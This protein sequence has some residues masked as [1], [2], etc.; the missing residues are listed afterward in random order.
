MHS[1]TGT[2]APKQSLAGVN[3]LP[4]AVFGLGLV[5]RVFFANVQLD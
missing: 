3:A 1:P 2:L 5:L 4:T